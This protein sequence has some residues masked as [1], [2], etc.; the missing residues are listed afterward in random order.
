MTV[1]QQTQTNLP[2]SEE[3]LAVLGHELR[4]PLSALSY[5]LQAW[6]TPHDTPNLPEQALQEHLLQIMRRQVSH[7]TRLCNDLLDTGRNACGNLRICRDSV[8]VR[9]VVEDACEQIRPFADQ[10][11]HRLTVALAEHRVELIGDASRLT[12]VL[13]NMI[14][15][16]AKFTDYGG[17]LS[18]S[19][20]TDRDS[21]VIKLQDNGRGIDADRLKS[22]FSPCDDPSNSSN[23]AGGGLGIGLRLA[24]SIVELHGG[25]I[26]AFS[27]GLGRG[28]TFVVKLPMTLEK[29]EAR[30]QLSTA[31]PSLKRVTAYS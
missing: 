11:G 26:E 1:T 21:A 25:S 28:S 15:N 7:M 9:Q 24:K 8:N 14:H 23:A 30:H 20:H 27:E 18:M 12:Q 10:C 16:S 29:G 31:S 6:P 17:H 19:L 22:I 2:L 4:N 3:R 5:A 13:A